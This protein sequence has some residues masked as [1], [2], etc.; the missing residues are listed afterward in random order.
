MMAMWELAGGFSSVSINFYTIFSITNS[1]V[2]TGKTINFLLF[3]LSS[4]HY[5]RKCIALLHRKFPR[6][7]TSSSMARRSSCMLTTTTTTTSHRS[8]E[9]RRLSSRRQSSSS[10]NTQTAPSL[11]RT[12]SRPISRSIKK[13]HTLDDISEIAELKQPF[14]NSSSSSN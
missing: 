4:R 6:L 5:R 7:S 8:D 12:N 14:I 11:V 9:Q 1:L 13:Q 10:M 3:C 2:V